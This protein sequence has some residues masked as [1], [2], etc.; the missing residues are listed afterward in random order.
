MANI[1]GGNEFS[2]QGGWAHPLAQGEELGV[3]SLLLH[4]KKGQLKWFGDLFWMPPWS[5]VPAR[6][7]W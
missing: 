4:I 3:E 7:H 5:G 1:S 6:P 2:P